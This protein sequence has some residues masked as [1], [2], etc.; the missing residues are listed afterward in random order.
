MGSR[1]DVQ[2]YGLAVQEALLAVDLR[3]TQ[4]RVTAARAKGTVLLRLVIASDGALERADVQRSSGNRAL[5][6]AAIQLARLIAFPRPPP[7]L[8][9][10]QR[11]YSAPIVF[12]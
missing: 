2:A 11:A 4:A 9:A 10:A 3:E 5:D 7:S 12:K 1:G 6:E 8:T